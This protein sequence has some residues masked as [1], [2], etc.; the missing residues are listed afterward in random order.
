V[1][2][3]LPN[4]VAEG[5]N[6]LKWHYSGPES[7]DHLPI[8][9]HEIPIVN[10][11]KSVF[12]KD[13]VFVDIGA[14]VGLYSLELASKASQV[15]AFEANE[16]TFNK[17]IANLQLNDLEDKVTPINAACWDKAELLEMYDPNGKEAGGSTLCRSVVEDG[18][19]YAITAHADKLDKLLKPYDLARIDMLKID[20]EG[21][22]SK[23]LKGARKTLMKHHPIVLVE[24]HDVFMGETNRDAV[25]EQLEA[26]GYS[27]GADIPY[28]DC[29]HWICRPDGT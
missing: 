5:P 9:G 16:L 20:V 22:E 19:T 14:H 6:G 17:L 28:G 21:A 4:T 3:L 24:M 18:K 23:V 26:A 12:P 29:Y 15:Y 2:K 7:D 10:I 1:S 27:H 8:L 11:A 25:E 13:G